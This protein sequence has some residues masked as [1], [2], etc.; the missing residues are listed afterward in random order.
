MEESFVMTTKDG[1]ICRI[2]PVLFTR[3]KVNNSTLTS[4]R[5]K[6]EEHLK[7]IFLQYTLSELF[8]FIISN[9]LQMELKAA[10]KKIYPI[11]S[12]EIKAFYT[13]QH[14]PAAQQATAQP[15]AQP[16][17]KVQSVQPQTI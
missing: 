6:A 15:L 12:C 17:V 7:Q 10:L 16:T 8:Q 4:L 2:K 3:H 5:K 14:Q 1:Q 9:K 11:S 13:E